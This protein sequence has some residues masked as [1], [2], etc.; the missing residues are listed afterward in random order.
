[1]EQVRARSLRPLVKARVFGMTPGAKRLDTKSPRFEFAQ[2]RLSRA[3]TARG[4]S[5]ALR[6]RTGQPSEQEV[7]GKGSGQECPLHMFHCSMLHRFATPQVMP[8]VSDIH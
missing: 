8:N 3:Q 7:N 1:M 4:L 5:A 2:G 6:A